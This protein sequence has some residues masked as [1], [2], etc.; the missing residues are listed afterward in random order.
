MIIDSKHV[1]IGK[2]FTRLVKEIFTGFIGLVVDVFVVYIHQECY[3]SLLL[4]VSWHVNVYYV[5]WWVTPVFIFCVVLFNKI[6]SM[7]KK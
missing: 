4:L 3:T 7:C 2:T 1:L 6:S 5:F